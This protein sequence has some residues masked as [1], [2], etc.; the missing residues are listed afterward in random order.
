MLLKVA[1]APVVVVRTP[2]FDAHFPIVLRTQRWLPAKDGS[3]H[4]PSELLPQELPSGFTRNSILC[5]E[6]GLKAEALVNLAKEAGLQVEDLMFIRQHR[7]E[8][9]KLKNSL[10]QRPATSAK[11]VEKPQAQPAPP[12]GPPPP[13]PDATPTAP[14]TGATPSVSTAQPPDDI[15]ASIEAILSSNN[16]ETSPTPAPPELSETQPHHG[17]GHRGNGQS[18]NGHG[19]TSHRGGTSGSSTGRGTERRSTSGGTPKQDGK[20]FTYVYVAPESGDEDTPPTEKEAQ[21]RADLGKAGMEFVL[22]FERDAGRQ[23]TEMSQTHEGYDVESRNSSAHVERFIEVKSI[24]GTW[25]SR[26]VTLSRPQFKAAREL[27]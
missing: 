2:S 19:G 13:Q 3:L 23:P 22:Q 12:P 11:P 8:F 25:G 27:E 4:K 1:P 10:K 21:E 18:G 7:D 24:S 17:N 20:Y 15:V 14:P 9:E 6:L 16:R 5:E 26:G